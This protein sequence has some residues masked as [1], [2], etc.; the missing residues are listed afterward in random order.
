MQMKQT[1]PNALL[2]RILWTILALIILGM[3]GYFIRE[4]WQKVIAASR[5]TLPSFEAVTPF[6]LTERSGRTVTDQDLRGLVWV[7]NFIFT[8]C[9]GPCPMMSQRMQGLQHAL[10]KTEKVK[11]VSFSVDPETDTPAVLQTYSENFYAKP[12]RW[13]FLTGGHEVV[14][15]LAVNAFRLPVSR[16][17]DEEVPK[18]GK[19]L[20]STRFVLV[21][22][23]GMI[24]G[25]YDSLDREFQP[26]LLRDIGF[27]MKEQ[28]L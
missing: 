19:F 4:S 11:L 8:T 24:R 7:A 13:W 12:D 18:F 26:H 22:I 9:P 5:V 6:S 28:G 23:N 27:L 2:H 14:Q 15:R 21:D 17:P 10:L 25:Y 16:N 1:K 20:H 3:V